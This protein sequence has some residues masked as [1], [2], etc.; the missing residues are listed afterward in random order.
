MDVQLLDAVHS[1]RWLLIVL[2]VVGVINA[3]LAALRIWLMIK[4]HIPDAMSTMFRAD[5]LAL[6]DADKF[7]ELLARCNECLATKPNHTDALWYRAKALYALKQ[8]GEARTALEKL[9]KIEPSWFESHI[10]PM[11]KQIDDVH[12]STPVKH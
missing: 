3:C 2:I 8:Y 4:S 11:L 1:I 9:A 12:D 10:E 7:D 5:A 6:V